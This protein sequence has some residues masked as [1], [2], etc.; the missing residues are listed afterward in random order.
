[1]PDEDDEVLVGEPADYPQELVDS[2]NDLLN[3]MPSIKKAWFL[4]VV[5]SNGSENFLLV[6]DVR[7][8]LEESFNMIN[9]VAKE[10]LRPGEIMDILPSFDRFGK[11][12]VRSYKPFHRKGMFSK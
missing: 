9:K 12:A 1:M 6:V 4:L 7:S 5:R 10:H 11:K 8:D 2:I 3:T